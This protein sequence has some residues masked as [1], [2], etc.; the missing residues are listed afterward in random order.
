MTFYD[1]VLKKLDQKIMADYLDKSTGGSSVSDD[2][3]YPAYCRVASKNG[4]MFHHFRR[5]EIYNLI[6]E[7]MSKE[8]GQEYLD[9]LI[10]NPDF[11]KISDRLGEYLRNDKV[12]KPRIYEY[13]I[14]NKDVYVSPTT[15]RYIKVLA[16]LKNLFPMNEI[17][18]VAEIGVGYGGQ[19]R[20]IL[21]DYEITRYS[22]IDLPEALGLT[23]RFLGK[24]TDLSNIH[25]VDGTAI[26]KE[27]LP[28][29]DLVISNYAYSELARV[30]QKAYWDKVV[31]KAAHGYFTWNLESERKLDGYTVDEF[32]KMLSDLGRDVRVLEEKPLTAPGNCLI[33]W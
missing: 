27:N 30:I 14:D 5:N 33:V 15:L 8:Q 12:G 4:F 21:S 7:H 32:T 9:E 13:D 19:C 16:D 26:D 10:K 20:I 11:K 1:K 25:F 31:S 3:R 2:G 18:S 28:E 29:H 22:L 23:K 6:L 24:L 17:K